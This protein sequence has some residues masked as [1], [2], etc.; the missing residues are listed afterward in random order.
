[1]GSATS[2]SW[3]SDQTGCA[4]HVGVLRER[5]VG[6]LLDAEQPVDDPTGPGLVALRP[7]R[8]AE[9]VGVAGPDEVV[10][11]GGR[12]QAVD[13]V[14]PHPGRRGRGDDGA[15]VELVLGGGQDQR[16]GEVLAPDARGAGGHLLQRADVPVPA[17]VVARRRAPERRRRGVA[18]GAPG[19]AG[20]RA[21]A[22]G[23]RGRP[24][25]GPSGHAADA[26]GLHDV[27]GAGAVVAAVEAVVV[28]QVGPAVV[29]AVEAVRGPRERRSGPQGRGDLTVVGD[30]RRAGGPGAVVGPVVVEGGVVQHEELVLPPVEGRQASPARASR[31]GPGRSRTRLVIRYLPDF[32]VLTCVKPRLRASGRLTRWRVSVDS[33]SVN[34]L[35]SV[36]MSS[37][38][39]TLGVDRSG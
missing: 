27:A 36:T 13:L 14:A 5:A 10:G 6:L 9:L 20:R 11:A 2:S 34:V 4:R 32:A 25:A 12:G 8:G 30:Q 24:V 37:R 1:M 21:E 22:E 23:Q 26:T 31:H 16:R 29:L 17:A 28:L 38:L 35:P 3:S 18:R 19:R 7:E 33:R 39:R 15:R